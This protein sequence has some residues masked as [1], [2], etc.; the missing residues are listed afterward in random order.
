MES[1][2]KEFFCHNCKKTFF[3]VLLNEDE[4]VTCTSCA[5]IFV[6]LIED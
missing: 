1:S 3:K 4:D 6:E 5:D 2:K